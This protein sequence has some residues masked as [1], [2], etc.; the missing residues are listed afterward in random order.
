MVAAIRQYRKRKEPTWR[1]TLKCS[2]TSAYSLTSL[3][4]QPGCFSPSHPTTSLTKP[5]SSGPRLF[6]RHNPMPLS[7]KN[8]GSI[9]FRWT[10]S[11]FLL[12]DACRGRSLSAFDG[13]QL[14]PLAPQVENEACDRSDG[15]SREDCRGAPRKTG[16][17]GG[18]LGGQDQ[19]H[20][21]HHQPKPIGENLGRTEAS[22]GEDHQLTEGELQDELTTPATITENAS[23]W[24]AEKE[25]ASASR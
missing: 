5:R 23:Q 9:F 14:L 6:Q 3:P 13:L 21:A 22:L 10:S 8:N 12:L 15:G 4:A 24:N 2:T 16:V 1:N 11:K 25:N 20:Q 17:L 19:A 18:S 7:V